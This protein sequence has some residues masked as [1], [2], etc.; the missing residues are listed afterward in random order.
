MWF[1]GATMY[2]VQVW[3]ICFT[4]CFL[5]GGRWDISPLHPRRFRAYLAAEPAYWHRALICKVF[6]HSKKLERHLH[7]DLCSR[8]RIVL[9][10]R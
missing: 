2:E 10:Q 6:G 4:Y 7:E 5:R 9:V 8:C 1:K 3:R